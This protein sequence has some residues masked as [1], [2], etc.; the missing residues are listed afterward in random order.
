MI[1]CSSDPVTEN[2]ALFLKEVVF[3]ATA[4]KVW[5]R[6]FGPKSAANLSDFI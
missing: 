4:G 6:S 2:F 3:E 1:G 5:Y